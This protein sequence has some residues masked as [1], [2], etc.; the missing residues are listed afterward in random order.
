VVAVNRQRN[1]GGDSGEREDEDQCCDVGL[2][3]LP[4]LGLPRFALNNITL[5]GLAKIEREAI[6]SHRDS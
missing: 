3:G 2:H 5:S 4:P 1:H 6:H